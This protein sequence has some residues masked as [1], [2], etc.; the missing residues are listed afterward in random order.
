MKLEKK[1]KNPE[2]NMEFKNYKSSKRLYCDDTCKNRSA[3]LKKIVEQGDLIE[4]DKSMRKNYK[5]LKTLSNLELG[6]ISMQTLKSHGF[7]FKAIHKAEPFKFD[8][9]E[10]KQLY[11]VYNVFF[12]MV[13]KCL[14]FKKIIAYESN[15]I[16]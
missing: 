7:N 16:N 6:P 12:E 15:N 3:Y 13:N 11:H 2:C 9:G 10:T 1:C 8:N 14:V 4:M 5:I